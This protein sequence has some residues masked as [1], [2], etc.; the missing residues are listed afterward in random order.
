MS[1]PGVE[2]SDYTNILWVQDV[3]RTPDPKGNTPLKF[4]ALSGSLEL[5]EK[6]KDLFEAEARAQGVKNPTN[7]WNEIADQ[8]VLLGRATNFVKGGKYVAPLIN[9]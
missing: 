8:V 1:V 2:K 7:F 4:F 9:Y 3:L 6:C 5:L